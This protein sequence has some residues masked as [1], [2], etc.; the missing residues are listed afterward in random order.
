M[1][2]SSFTFAFL[3]KALRLFEQIHSRKIEVDPIPYR[4]QWHSHECLLIPHCSYLTNVHLMSELT[5]V[6]NVAVLPEG[7][8]ISSIK[9]SI[10]F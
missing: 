7:L 4:T 5:S 9:N 10:Y 3:L 1:D 2:N 8:L 6:F